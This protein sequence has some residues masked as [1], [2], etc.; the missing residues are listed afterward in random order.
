FAHEGSRTLPVL[1][2]PVPGMTRF[3]AVGWIRP[4]YLWGGTGML[5]EAV[6]LCIDG[7]RGLFR[8]CRPRED[9]VGPADTRLT[10]RW[11][12]FL[13]ARFGIDAWSVE[14]SQSRSLILAPLNG[15]QLGAVP[16]AGAA[17][18]LTLFLGSAF[19]R[20]GPTAALVRASAQLGPL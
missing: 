7:P 4:E 20:R 10:A 11:P 6:Q 18:I 17:L 12:L 5:S 9:Q 14:A 3:F 15:T 16:L 2:R 19:I 8:S 1:V 13:R